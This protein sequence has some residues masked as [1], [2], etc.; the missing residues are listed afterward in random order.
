MLIDHVVDRRARG[1][2]E[3]DTEQTE[4]EYIERYRALGREQHADHRG[5]HD[6][7]YDLGF[8]QVIVLGPVG[9]RQR[10]HCNLGHL[11]SSANAA[12]YRQFPRGSIAG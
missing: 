5:E 2:R 1:R 7:E 6:Q 12:L 3:P 10:G 4:Y 9:K 11:Q 8:G